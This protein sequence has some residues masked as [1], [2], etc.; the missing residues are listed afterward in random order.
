MT[1]T[2]SGVAPLLEREDELSAVTAAVD[3]AATGQGGALVVEG[4]AGIGKTRLLDVARA[5]ATERGYRVLTARASPLERGFGFGVVRGLLEPVLRTADPAERAALFD[6]AARLAR[7]VL[8]PGEHAPAPTFATLHGIYWLLAGLAEDR[9]LLLAVDDAHW[10]DAPS[11]RAL[12]HL[13]RR[14]EELPVLLAVTARPPEPGSDS[15]DLL[16]EL[17]AEPATTVVHPAPLSAAAAGVLVR[18][19]FPGP[20]DDAFVAA[21]HDA[22]AGNPLLLGALVRSLHQADVQPLASSVGAVGERAPAIVGTFVLPRLRHLPPRASA[23]ARALAVLGGG[24]EVRHVAAVADLDPSEA[25][26]AVDEL[27]AAELVT[28]GPRPAFVHPLVAQAV[29]DR[30]PTAERQR[31]HRTAAAELAADGAPPEAVAAHLLEV[32]PLRD[33]WVVERLREAARG[34]LAKGAPQPAVDYLSRA[35]TEPPTPALRVEVLYELG[36]AETHLGP[37]AGLD[38]MAEALAATADPRDRVRMALRLAR[39]LET[40]W[41]LPRA[42]DVLSAAVR[43]ADRVDGLDPSLRA[44][45]EAE[46]I[47]LARSRSATRADALRRL[48]RLLPSAD[49]GTV[50]GCVLLATS[51]VELLQEPGRTAEA[52]GRARAAIEGALR[53][54]SASFITGILYLAAPVLAAAG[55]LT[56]ALAGAEGA[57][58]DARARGALVELGAA[59]GSRAEMSRRLGRLL[60]AEADV[61]PAME[62]RKAPAS[63]GPG[64]CCSAPSCR[65]SSSG[66]TLPPRRPRSTAWSSVSST[67]PSSPGSAGYA[68]RR[69]ARPRPSTSCST[70]APGWSSAAGC[71][72]DC[73]RGRPTPRSPATGSAGTTRRASGPRKPS[74]SPSGTTH[75]SPS[76]SPAARSAS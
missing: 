23:V 18:E 8:D 48:E 63:R 13:A 74:P 36:A 15:A 68:W 29:A 35:L 51:S 65:C 54:D 31:A 19:V 10:A 37:M 66:T 7:P 25:A 71:I 56:T 16:D 43:D 42:L 49:A 58:A 53:Q 60:D 5:T 14:I 32:S 4:P 73:C 40:A 11:L 22:S 3:A 27:A 76:A 30:M 9:P 2:V 24:A 38:R 61:R 44:L 55:D 67:P 57:V 6:G 28:P 1:R 52:V 20:A 34:A 41:E 45:V 62:R 72:P 17:R 59:L 75:P 12:H 33:A 46:Y 70:R 39:G 69:T 64:G 47:G 50:A 26:R 21:C